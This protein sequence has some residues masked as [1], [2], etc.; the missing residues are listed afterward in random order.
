MHGRAMHIDVMRNLRKLRRHIRIRHLLSSSEFDSRLR[1]EMHGSAEFY[2][3]RR[4]LETK[5]KNVPMDIPVL[6]R[7]YFVT[8]PEE[9]NPDK[10]EER[11]NEIQHINCATRRKNGLPS[12]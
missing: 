10:Q 11:R 12:G 1:M 2:A 6:G 9:P 8:R 3:R 7:C 5:D 4:K